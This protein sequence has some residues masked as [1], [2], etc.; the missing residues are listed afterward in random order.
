MR[1]KAGATPAVEKNKPLRPTPNIITADNLNEY[2]DLLSPLIDSLNEDVHSYIPTGSS[3]QLLAEAKV[4]DYEASKLEGVEPAYAAEL[5]ARAEAKR[6]LA[7]KASPSP[8]K[9]AENKGFIAEWEAYYKRWL[10]TYYVMREKLKEIPFA[11][12]KGSDWTT[13][14]GYDLEY[15]E[16][17]NRYEKMGFQLT[18]KIPPAAPDIP[19]SN[20]PWG[21][22]AAG[23]VVIGVAITATQI[24]K[25]VS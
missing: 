10:K 22:I 16:L 13:M 24:S 17:S 18:M 8:A 3:E 21:W 7:K 9:I 19:G 14:Q 1:A 2:V 23:V 4:L 11:L 25:A 12:T 5:R 20:I 6:E 15:Q